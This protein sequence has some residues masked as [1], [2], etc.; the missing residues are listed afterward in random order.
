[1]NWRNGRRAIRMA[2]CA[3]AAVASVPAMHCYAGSAAS[4]QRLVLDGDVSAGR[5]WTAPIGEGWRFRLVPILALDGALSGWDMVVDRIPPSGF[6][7]ALYLATPPYNS[8]SEREI[9]TTY[10][11]RAQDTIGWNPRSFRYLTDP[12]AFREAQQDYHFAF[13]LHHDPAP[14]KMIAAASARLLKLTEGASAGELKILDAHLSPGIA[15]PAPFAQGWARAS[16][17]TQHEL[18]PSPGGKKASLGTLNWM[19]FEVVLWLPPGWKP[20]PGEKVQTTACGQ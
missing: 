9:A 15:D 6:P 11:L 4:C 14:K 3:I 12:A 20:P 8:I 10:G 5:E 16:S 2:V 13:E 7:D 17:Q 19:R 18:D 1:M